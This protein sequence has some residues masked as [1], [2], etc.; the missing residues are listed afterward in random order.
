MNY[1]CYYKGSKKLKYQKSD[2]SFYLLQVKITYIKNDNKLTITIVII[3]LTVAIFKNESDEI[4]SCFIVSNFK[5][6]L[7]LFIFKDL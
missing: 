1:F 7:V 5:I 6:I 3:I 4:L 2:Q